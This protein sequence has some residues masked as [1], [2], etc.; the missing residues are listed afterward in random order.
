M[1]SVHAPPV[2]DPLLVHPSK[3]VL[4]ANANGDVPTATFPHE[5]THMLVVGA[6][7]NEILTVLPGEGKTIVPG[8]ASLAEQRSSNACGSQQ[9]FPAAEVLLPWIQA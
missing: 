1:S 7:T 2:C 8:Q 5:R 4:V 9:Y 6:T 3:C